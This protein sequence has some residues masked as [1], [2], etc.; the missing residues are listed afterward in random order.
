MTMRETASLL[1][2][3]HQRV[4]QLERAALAKGWGQ[5]TLTDSA[6]ARLARA[7]EAFALARHAQEE[8]AERYSLGY[9]EE[10][11]A[12]YG[13]QRLAAADE[14]EQRL[15]WRVGDWHEAR[16]AEPA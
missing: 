4:G 3:S 11:R 12:F 1:G 15:T 14:T 13:D 10:R 6:A 16:S 7:R 5:V 2:I 8:R 9:S